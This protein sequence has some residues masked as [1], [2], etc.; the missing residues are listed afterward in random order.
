MSNAVNYL[1]K[2]KT[3]KETAENSQLEGIINKGVQKEFIAH[4]LRFTHSSAGASN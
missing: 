1:K 3:S 2:L 4:N